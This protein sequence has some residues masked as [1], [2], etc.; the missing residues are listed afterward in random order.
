MLEETQGY[1]VESNIT[2]S[3]SK[4][5]SQTPKYRG[6]AQPSS[7]F[8]FLKR[9]KNKCCSKAMFMLLLKIG[10]V[11]VVLFGAS[12]VFFEQEVIT[13]SLSEM[14]E[15][16]TSNDLRYYK[17]EKEM[18]NI[19]E[20]QEHTDQVVEQLTEKVNHLS[21]QVEHLLS[22]QPEQEKEENQEIISSTE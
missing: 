12:Y 21:M 13:R 22:P 9:A 17:V 15:K 4:L 20:S 3:A 16:T 10:L 8:G 18:H 19:E 7:R 5:L 14:W 6:S 11:L 2:D 1:D